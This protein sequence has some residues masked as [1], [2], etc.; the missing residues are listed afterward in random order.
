MLRGELVPSDL[1]GIKEHAAARYWWSKLKTAGG[2]LVGPLFI[3]GWIGVYIGREWGRV[4]LYVY[5]AIWL[6]NKVIYL[7]LMGADGVFKFSL[8]VGM[9]VLLIPVLRSNSWSA[10]IGSSDT[11]NADSSPSST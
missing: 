10:W 2:L 9:V 3:L 11:V 8:A 6:A 4:C 1:A 5:A 7:L